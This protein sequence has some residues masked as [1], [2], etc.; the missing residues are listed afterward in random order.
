MEQII[1][2]IL[3]G[4][5][6]MFSPELRKFAVTLQYYS[7]K[8]YTYVRKTFKN[9]LPHPRTLRRW[10][11]VVDGKPG[12]TSEA[13]AVL[14]EKCKIDPVYC[15]L[16]VDEVCIKKYVEVDTQN[17]V[18]GYIDLGTGQ[19]VDDDGSLPFAR[20]SLVFLVVGLNA[21]W[22]LPIAYFLIDS[23]TGTERGNLL[24]KAIELISETG[25]HVHSVTFDGTNVN[26][27]MCTSLGANFDLSNPK[28]YF[29]NPTTKE[30]V[31]TFYDPAHM[32]KLIR[33]TF[34]DR[35]IIMNSKNE[36]ICWDYIVKLY[37]KEKNEGL[38]AGTKLTSKH[39]FYGNQKMNVRLAAQVLSNSV[40]DALLFT[41][42]K[43][44]LFDGCIAT[45]EFCRMFNNAFD[46]LN[47]R[48]MLSKSPYNGAI[49]VE[50]F[51]TYETFYES[52]KVYTAQLKFYDGTLIINSKRKT[53]FIGLILGLKNALD[54]FKLLLN[55]GDMY[56][57][58]TYK[59]SQDHLETFFSALRSRGGYND[60]PTC[61]EFQASY[62]R[63]L[64]HNEVIA[65][66]F[67]NCSILDCT[68]IQPVGTKSIGNRIDS[69]NLLSPLL[70]E[71][72]VESLINISPFIEDITSYIAGFVAKRIENK[73]KCIYCIQK[74]YG[75]H[76]IGNLIAIK[77]CGRLKKPSND[78]V[79]IC[80]T[81]EKVF[82]TYSKNIP[83]SKRNRDMLMLK[84]KTNIDS[85][86][87]NE[88]ECVHNDPNLC[89]DLINLETHRDY[90]IKCIG[91]KYFDI[92]TFH[93]IRK[94]NDSIK[95]RQKLTKMIHFR[96]D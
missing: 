91:H 48:Q 69:N 34:G 65:S 35:K 63:L 23:M 21:Y 61:R 10:Y 92:R 90:L 86:I 95:I 93:E 3:D 29:I 30:K 67:G 25:A 33:N 50:N 12:F 53:G 31:Y 52:F 55:T 28:P 87:L 4:K 45:A 36:I 76:H 11:M 51:K 38:R 84:L 1:K 58:L 94:T 20:N 6:K 68:S 85:S 8:A 66:P 72:L 57:L 41:K 14:K 32:I 16:T 19:K 27:T 44:P 47:A 24:K 81:A 78:L 46:I 74:I 17:N 56:Y 64:I 2:E 43:D 77:D 18:Y 13:F 37:N 5:K 88:M 79:S 60:N 15:N 59:I 71:E 22:K 80:K 49:T 39:I 96:N 83:L 75:Q 40:S 7:P 89:F 70:D 82:R 42:T 54:L 73:I 9:I 26:T 62:K